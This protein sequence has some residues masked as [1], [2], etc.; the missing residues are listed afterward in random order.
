MNEQ[1]STAGSTKQSPIMNK[2]G[3]VFIPVRNIKEARNW[4]CRVLGFQ[5]ADC[6]IMNDHLCPLPMQ[7]TG[8]ILDTMPMWGG[9]EPEGAPTIQ[10]PAFMFLTHDLHGSLAYMKEL[11]VEL[12]TEIEHDHWFVVKDPDGN[13]LMICRE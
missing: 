12:V 9:Q 11:G 7:G 8:I 4:Y 2:I 6:Q 3:S 5:E 1:Q 13:K 10:T